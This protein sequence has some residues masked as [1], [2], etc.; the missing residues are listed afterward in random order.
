MVCLGCER[1]FP[2]PRGVARFVG[3]QNYANS[4]GFQWHR[5]D[6]TQLDNEEIK[7]AEVHFRMKTGFRPED[8]KGKWVLDVGC[9][10]GRFAEVATRWG[11]QVIGV[12]LSAAAEVAAR[13]LAARDFTALQADVFFLPFAPESFDYIYSIGVLHHT[14]DCEKAVK[15]L[16]QYLKPGGR[17]AICA[18]LAGDRPH[19]ADVAEQ[20][21]AVC[22]GFLCPSLG[23]TD[24]Y[25]TWM[26]DAG[27]VMD[28]VHDWTARV[29]DTWAI[30][31]RRIR[32]SGVKW[33]ARRVGPEMEK[34]ATRFETIRQAYLS[35]AMKYG[36][37]VFHR[38]A[39]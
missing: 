37:F 39:C 21:R 36:C 12:D 6:R 32:A 27:L 3:P 7:E 22:E 29:A 19:S 35:G 28:S 25:L 8:L 33:L 26:T 14:P 31:E 2:A 24:D 1:V 16:P 17:M 9:G 15:V 34:F 18:W 13:N 38:P 20:V 10:M 4:F 23:T 11:A 30:C 5:Y